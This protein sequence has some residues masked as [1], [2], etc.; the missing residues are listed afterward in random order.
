MLLHHS[1]QCTRNFEKANFPLFPQPISDEAKSLPNTEPPS[2]SNSQP[3]EEK[4]PIPWEAEPHRVPDPHEAMASRIFSPLLSAQFCVLRCVLS[5][6]F[7]CCLFCPL[8]IAL[9]HQYDAYQRL[10]TQTG[11]VTIESVSS[12]IPMRLSILPRHAME[13]PPFPSFVLFESE[14]RRLRFSDPPYYLR[15]DCCFRHSNLI[16]STYIFSFCPIVLFPSSPC[17]DIQ[18]TVPPVLHF[19]FVWQSL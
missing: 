15:L 14:S 12:P 3:I 13:L 19:P 7:H 1:R 2:W 9:Q 6:L 16:Q 10:S 8:N 5:P 11:I 4:R 17:L 18:I